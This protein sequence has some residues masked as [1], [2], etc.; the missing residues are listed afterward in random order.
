MDQPPL[1]FCAAHLDASSFLSTRSAKTALEQ[2]RGHIGN[3]R[4]AGD[5]FDNAKKVTGKLSFGEWIITSQMVGGMALSDVRNGDTF[6]SFSPSI[7][8][9]WFKPRVSGRL[10]ILAPPHSRSK[11]RDRVQAAP[12]NATA[13]QSRF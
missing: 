11:H 8:S 7:T 13:A 5:G 10:V 6:T 1:G 12:T 9:R 2:E 3:A 4:V